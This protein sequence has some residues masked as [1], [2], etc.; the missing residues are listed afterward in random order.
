MTKFLPVLFPER[1]YAMYP[2]NPL[3]WVYTCASDFGYLACMA[4]EEQ[5]DLNDWHFY[6]TTK[7]LFF[8]TAWL[9]CFLDSEESEKSVIT[10]RIEF[11][12][13][14]GWYCPGKPWD[15]PDIHLLVSWGSDIKKYNLKDVRIL[16]FINGKLARHLC[17]M[18]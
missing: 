5:F 4:E 12:D 1:P 16:T 7:I 2:H 15:N 3:Y 13:S 11:K 17:V 18:R 6:E 14:L 9:D 8:G 10:H